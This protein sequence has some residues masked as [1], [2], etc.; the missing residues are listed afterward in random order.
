MA[1][2]KLFLRIFYIFLFLL[3]L[4][5]GLVGGFFVGNLIS[6]K[7]F[8]FNKYENLT[9]EMLRDDLSSISIENKTPA[10]FSSGIAFQ[11]AEQ[12]MLSSTKYEARGK[13]IVNTSLGVT[14][15][16]ST[17]DKRDGDN[18]YLGFTTFSSMVKTSRQA[19][20]HIGG[21]VNMQT[22][23]PTDGTIENVKWDN[24]F[25]NYTW[26]EYKELFGKYANYNSSYI[27]STKTIK[28]D[29][30]ME[31]DGN[32][33]KFSVLL[34]NDLSTVGYRKQ[35]GNNV[36][37]NPNAV[38]FN[39]LELTFWIDKN[40]KFTKQTKFE[41]YTI[42]YAGVNVTLELTNEAIYNIY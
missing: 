11:L 7:Y 9:P 39:R 36:G 33:Y 8:I 17:L 38:I 35:I 2:N 13:G 18:L 3:V 4:S 29:Y 6:S 34:D 14:Q 40:F 25:D 1:K 5:F 21:D 30:K 24:Q 15:E 41:S 42:P 28:E 37:I 27:V 20:Y 12:V 31:M 10:D 22:G 32:L 16:S 19:H 23:T 26:E